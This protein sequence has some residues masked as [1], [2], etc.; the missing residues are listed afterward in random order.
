MNKIHPTAII[1]KTAQIGEGNV[2]GPW[3]VIGP[4]VF[5]GDRNWI[6]S[7][8]SIGMTG[9]VYGLPNIGEAWWTAPVDANSGNGL[10]IGD[11]NVIKEGVTIHSGWKLKTEIGNY[12][13]IMPKVH[14][15]HDCLL[16]NHVTLAP[17]VM[18]A[19]HSLMC[20]YVTIGMGAQ[21][22]Q[23][24]LIGPGAMI[25][26]GSQIRRPVSPFIKVVGE[27]QTPTKLNVHLLQKLNLNPIQISSVKNYLQN[28]VFLNTVELPISILELLQEWEEKKIVKRY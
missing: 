15:G 8:V 18:I 24:S 21:I 6:G 5:I 13:Y 3:T 20:S 23:R 2:I 19:G 25:G 27:K 17:G 16:M 7:S 9:D 28:G 4:G 12:S 14:I 22:H 1:D 26:M 11:E 10:V